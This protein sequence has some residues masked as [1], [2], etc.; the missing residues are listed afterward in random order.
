MNVDIISNK[1]IL[2]QGALLNERTEMDATNYYV[3][4]GDMRPMSDLKHLF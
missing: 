4:S 2:P 1:Y 3:Q